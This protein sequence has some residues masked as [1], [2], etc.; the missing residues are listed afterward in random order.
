[1]ID[2]ETKR[3]FYNTYLKGVQ[4]EAK[5]GAV[6]R[7]MSY[8]EWSSELEVQMAADRKKTP[9]LYITNSYLRDYAEQ[10]VRNTKRSITRK[11]TRA[12]E[13]TLVEGDWEVVLGKDR[14]AL[15]KKLLE[16][17]LTPKKAADVMRDI[18]EIDGEI[19]RIHQMIEDR[20]ADMPAPKTDQESEEDYK[21][22]VRKW[23]AFR[24]KDFTDELDKISI[25][26]WHIFFNS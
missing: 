11:Q 25:R 24:G 8:A 13:R 2:S 3:K 22:R 12:L 1:M 10:Q 19:D 4:R 26:S 16:G 15:E 17:N 23:F 7:P 21:R 5:R 20:F 9:G 14:E 18:R 6:D